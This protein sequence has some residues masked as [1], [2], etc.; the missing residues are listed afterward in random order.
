MFIHR[1]IHIILK[2]FFRSQRV[3]YI[4][5]YVSINIRTNSTQPDNSDIPFR[6]RIRTQVDPL[7]IYNL[8]SIVSLSV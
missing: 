1:Y 5:M 6:Q 4:C 8:Y 3:L 2:S 7:L